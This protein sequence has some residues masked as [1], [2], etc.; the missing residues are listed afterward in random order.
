MGTKYLHLVRHGQYIMDKD[1]KKYGQLT[2]LGRFQARRTGKRL[3]EYAISVVHVSTMIRAQE[4]GEIVLDGLNSVKWR[5][6]S[7]L[8]EGIPQFPKELIK[9]QKLEKSKI[10]EAKQRMDSAFKK[11]FNPY[12][13]KGERHEVL[14]CHGNIIRYLVAKSIE[15][16]TSKWINF[17]IFQCSI[18]TVAIEPDGKRRLLTFGEIGHIPIKK[19][20]FL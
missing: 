20:T 13:G 2:T 17:D 11:F 5:N 19:R 1:Q 3:N 15:V 12:K 10:R 16:D 8:I 18:S 9:R 14:V 7:L 6:S 4:T